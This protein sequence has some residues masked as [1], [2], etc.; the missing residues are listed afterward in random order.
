M[1]S[2]LWCHRRY[3]WWK[4]LKNLVAAFVLRYF[5]NKWKFW[6][7]EQCLAIKVTSMHIGF[8]D[9]IIYAA[10]VL[11]ALKKGEVMHRVR[12]KRHLKVKCPRWSQCWNLEMWRLSKRTEGQLSR[13]MQ[14]CAPATQTCKW[15]ESHFLTAPIQTCTHPQCIAGSLKGLI[16]SAFLWLSAPCDPASLCV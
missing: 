1:P 14:T 2:P 13:T 7:F 15:R 5:L 16:S 4:R 10:S 11:V 9:A 12:L 8:S 6:Q 3:R